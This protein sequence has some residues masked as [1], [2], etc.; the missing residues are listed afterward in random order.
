V[1]LRVPFESFAAVVERVLGVRDA[2]VV[3]H[4]AGCLVT[5]AD[6]ARLA[7]VASVAETG[8]EETRAALAQL[9]FEVFEGQW[10]MTDPGDLECEGADPYVAAVGYASGEGQAGVWVDAYPSLPTTVHVL[11]TMYD[12]FRETGELGDVPFEEFVR[13]AHPNVVI[14]SPSDLRSYLSD[15]TEPP[16]PT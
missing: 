10:S 2:F 11:R 6:P 8:P 4:P 16:T 9:G 5:A 13:L 7:T 15:K 3:R 14:V 12:E 1:T